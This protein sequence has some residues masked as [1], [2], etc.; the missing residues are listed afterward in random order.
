MQSNKPTTPR[1]RN[2]PIPRQTPMA[3]FY[4]HEVINEL[5]ALLS[6]L[7]DWAKSCPT[8]DI[9]ELEWANFMEALIHC[10]G[11]LP[12]NNGVDSGSLPHA[13]LGEDPRYVGALGARLRMTSSCVSNLITLNRVRHS[14]ELVFLLPVSFSDRLRM[15]VGEGLLPSVKVTQYDVLTC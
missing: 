10:F 1:L 11:S 3:L 9:S 6:G 12:P 15:L 8:P 14:E 2:R 4:W 5:D 13:V 7:P